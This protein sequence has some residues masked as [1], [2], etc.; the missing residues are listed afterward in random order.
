VGGVQ[1][2]VVT[3]PTSQERTKSGGVAFGGRENSCVGMMIT[4]GNIFV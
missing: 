2:I 1:T 4:V 3:A